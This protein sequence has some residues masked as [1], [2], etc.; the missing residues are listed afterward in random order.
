MILKKLTRPKLKKKRKLLNYYQLKQQLLR[1][2]L[3]KNTLKKTKK[4]KKCKS[5]INRTLWIHNSL[6]SLPNQANFYQVFSI[7][8]K[9]VTSKKISTSNSKRN[10]R[11]KN[12][13]ISLSKKNKLLFKRK[14]KNEKKNFKSLNLKICLIQRKKRNRRYRED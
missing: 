12:S 8:K 13:K 7:N 1:L 5:Q 3:K 4:L 6:I 11:L 2:N 14:K 10:S 9:P